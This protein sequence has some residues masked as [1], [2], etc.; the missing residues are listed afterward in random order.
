MEER[1]TTT[2]DFREE[3]RRRWPGEYVGDERR[4]E[5]LDPL[6]TDQE[7]DQSPLAQVVVAPAAAAP[8]GETAAS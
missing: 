8:G 2:A 1:V 6:E 5:P 4:K 3:R 7:P